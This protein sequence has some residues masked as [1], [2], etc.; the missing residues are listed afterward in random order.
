MDP[1]TILERLIATGYIEVGYEKI[2]RDVLAGLAMQGL[3][4]SDT[5]NDWPVDELVDWSVK[6]AD[7]LI[8][9][10]DKENEHG[11]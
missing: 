4:A 7:A 6:H 9:E 10:L 11:D 5:E 8:D 2:R 1:A 3:L